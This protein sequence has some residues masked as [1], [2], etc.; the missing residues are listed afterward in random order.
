MNA[1]IKKVEYNVYRMH[2]VFREILK[3]LYTILCRETEKITISIVLLLQGQLQNSFI[4]RRASKLWYF[5]DILVYITW[6]GFALYIYYCIQ[7]TANLQNNL[8]KDNE[9]I[10]WY[11]K[12]PHQNEVVYWRFCRQCLIFP[13]QKELL[14]YFRGTY[15]PSV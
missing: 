11:V 13:R 10:V 12:R 15:Y 4:N 3:S 9:K 2:F 1:V 7:F 14:E 8:G 6:T 5:N